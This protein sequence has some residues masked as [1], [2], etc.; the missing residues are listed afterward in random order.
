[1]KSQKAEGDFPMIYYEYDKFG[2]DNVITIEEYSDLDYPYLHFHRNYELMCL[3]DGALKIKLDNQTVCLKK[4]EFLLIHP[5]QIHAV[6]SQG[7]AF[8][9]V[10]IFSPNVVN[11]FYLKTL[12]LLPEK[13]ITNL[14][15]SVA[16]FL[17]ENLKKNSPYFLN[18]ACLYAVCSEI[19]RQ[20]VYLPYQ[21]SQNS[22]LIHQIIS[23]VSQN[24]KN[25]ITLKSIAESLGY[26]Y[27]YFS[28]YLHKYTIDFT[29]LLNQ[30]RLDYAKYLLKNSNFSITNI[31]FECGYNNMRTFNRNF[32][33]AFHVTPKKYRKSEISQIV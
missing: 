32:L 30:Y 21:S 27:Q 19:I 20:T 2:K 16:A 8:T 10:C 31:A 6:Y 22:T 7:H 3:Y 33:K 25:N 14:S 9:R 17:K 12:N 28:N 23:Y 24:F 18:K 15:D 26:N 11:E 13:I 5:N 1:M 4:G 29:S